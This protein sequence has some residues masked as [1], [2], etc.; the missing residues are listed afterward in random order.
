MSTIG[1]LNWQNENARTGYPLVNNEL[2]RNNLIVDAAFIQFDGFVPTLQ[3]IQVS[4]T[5]LIVT[6]LF[7]I[8]SVSVNLNSSDFATGI[9]HISFYDNANNYNKRYLGRIVFGNGVYDLWSQSVSQIL[10]FNVQFEASIVR[11]IPSA[12]GV[13]SIGGFFGDLEFNG[14]DTSIFFNTHQSPNWITFN[15]VENHKLPSVAPL[16]FKQINLVP[17]TNNNIYIGDND[18][19]NITNAFDGSVLVSLVGNNSPPNTSIISSLA[20]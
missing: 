9:R 3:T 14:N 2:V 15:A 17:P 18:V 12:S 19:I 13:F 20:S 16:V 6:V 11:S 5:T 8:G 1:I 7:D 10:T 4:A